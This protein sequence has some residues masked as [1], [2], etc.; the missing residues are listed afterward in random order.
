M[1]LRDTALTLLKAQQWRRKLSPF[2]PL[3]DQEIRLLCILPGNDGEPLRCS[4]IHY[5]LAAARSAHVA[6][7]YP[8]GPPEDP[9]HPVTIDGV[10]FAVRDNAYRILMRLRQ[11]N[12]MVKVW[13]DSLCINQEDKAEKS[14]Q[15]QLMY[16]IYKRA[17][18]TIIWLGSAEDAG[19]IV[20]YIR[21]I[22]T[23]SIFMEFS[24][25][26]QELWR[27]SN[28][29]FILDMVQE[30]PRKEYLVNGMARL[31][32]AAYFTRVWIRQ[33][34]ALGG[35]PSALWGPHHLS[36]KQL[37]VLAWLYR[38]R[39]TME[40]PGW[41]KFDYRSLE[42]A[43]ETILSINAFRFREAF[44]NAEVDGIYSVSG[45]PLY[46]QIVYS[47]SGLTT[48]AHDKIYALTGICSDIEIGEA[49]HV[50]A[51][52]KPD[53]S[54]S[55]QE[56]Y[57]GAAKFVTSNGN[58]GKWQFLLAAGLQSMGASSDLPSWVPDWRYPLHVMFVELGTWSAGGDRDNVRTKISP[59]SKKQKAQLLSF[60]GYTTIGPLCAQLPPDRCKITNSELYQLLEPKQLLPPDI[61]CA[62]P[63][64][65][66]K[67]SKAE[68]AYLESA[69]RAAAILEVLTTMQD[70]IVFVGRPSAWRTE[71]ELPR[72]RTEIMA[73]DAANVE[74]LQTQITA[75]REFYITDE[76]L[77]IAYDTTLIACQNAQ[78]QPA[79]ASLIAS[80]ADW[81]SW[82]ADP[83]IDHLATRHTVPYHGALESMDTFRDHVFAYTASG[84]IC[85]VPSHTHPGDKIVV[86]TGYSVPFVVRPTTQDWHMLVG[87]C[88]VHGMMTPK[89][90][91]L[92][93]EFLVKFDEKTG[94]AV[95]KRPQGDVRANGLKMEAGR[96]VDILETLGS[97]WL[98]LI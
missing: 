41:I 78:S 8:W 84:Y 88:Y 49:R 65:K 85:L 38:P 28:K 42:Y 16:S 53:Y 34:A 48:K 7:S 39:V 33:E 19:E 30:H 57:L 83:S 31:L 69:S 66:D 3:G 37:A 54:L 47:R 9:H 44:W 50:N 61:R 64:C 11:S 20:D 60:K 43:T 14:T 89:A 17:S 56:V 46:G 95:V 21:T 67:I 29:S 90:S 6:I 15:I 40:W 79:D 82:L 87:T 98:K 26:W 70:K 1:N 96:Y 45:T 72:F 27:Y 92:M 32:S 13:I 68:Y 35:N 94:R 63:R 25:G 75:G 74:F 52:I 76:T 24:P 81:R 2:Q 23:E 71:D 58:C 18:R 51:L 4:L 10:E 93:D 59:M 22:D 86:V 62:D 55:W 97:R 36:W 77:Q 80:A 91:E 5:N 73:N 12:E